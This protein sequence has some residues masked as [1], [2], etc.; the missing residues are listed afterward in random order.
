[1]FLRGVIDPKREIDKLEKEKDK[2]EKQSAGI[3]KRRGDA[4]KY[5]RV[6]AEAQ[7]KDS[8]TLEENTARLRAIDES[9]TQFRAML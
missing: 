6:P 1:M 2:L 9:L 7:A 4:D 8:A 5:A 3:L